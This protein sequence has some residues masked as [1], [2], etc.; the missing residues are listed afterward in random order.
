MHRHPPY[1]NLYVYY[2]EGCPDAEDMNLGKDFI[3]NWQEDGFSF[4]FFSESADGKVGRLVS[5]QPHLALIDR[6]FMTYDEWQGGKP[7]SMTV[8]RFF[9]HPPWINPGIAPENGGKRI[10][11]DP[12]VV[13]GNGMH[14]TTRD[15][16]E[17]IDRLC[18]EK[19]IETVIDLGT[20]T[21]LLAIAS[22]CMG[23]RRALAVDFNH[24]AAKTARQNVLLN[25]MEK[26]ILVIQG[27]AEEFVDRPAD[28]VIA[29]IHYDVMKDLVNAGAF[30]SPK[31]FI[32]SGLLK[33]QAR[34]IEHM[35][36]KLPLTVLDKL[37]YDN[38]WHTLI[39]RV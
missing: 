27:R 9:I 17:A 36:N 5:R 11:L 3:G 26:K 16:L 7:A 23:C 34:D 6:Y 25:R 35:L 37:E 12:G 4:L 20:G 2:I 10:L 29:N 24:L 1:K 13:F 19:H 32:L 39:G 18:Y 31:W 30:S 8:G 38:I 14:P 28:L 22:V 33:S 15:C 21:G